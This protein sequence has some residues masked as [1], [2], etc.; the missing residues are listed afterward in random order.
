MCR[1]CDCNYVYRYYVILL[2]M[3]IR[4]QVGKLIDIAN[5]EREEQ[6][7]ARQYVQENDIMLMRIPSP[8]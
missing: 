5:L 4:D 2:I 3:D 8:F 7:L 1:N 6:E